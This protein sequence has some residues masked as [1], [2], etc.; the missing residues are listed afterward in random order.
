MDTRQ[1]VMP[2]RLVSTQCSRGGQQAWVGVGEVF[3]GL[4]AG[5][6]GKLERW[7]GGWKD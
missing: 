7:E 3:E 4:G 6:K 1:K 2:V 5:S